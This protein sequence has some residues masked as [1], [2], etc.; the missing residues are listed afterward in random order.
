MILR[1][2]VKRESRNEDEK[3][4]TGGN[5]VIWLTKPLS[6]LLIAVPFPSYFYSYHKLPRLLFGFGRSE[7]DLVIVILLYLLETLH[8][9]GNGKMRFVIRLSGLTTLSLASPI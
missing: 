5:N 8:R 3:G 7:P 4:N 6:Q 9:E 2:K 1:R